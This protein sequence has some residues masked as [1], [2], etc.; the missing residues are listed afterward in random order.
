MKIENDAIK[1]V[2]SG[3]GVVVFSDPKLGLKVIR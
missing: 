3:T 1:G 2:G